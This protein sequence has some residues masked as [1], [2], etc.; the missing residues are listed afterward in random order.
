MNLFQ[1][2]YF[3]SSHCYRAVHRVKTE[4]GR[5]K[6][7]KTQIK[8]RKQ[9][10]TERTEQGSDRGGSEGGGGGERWRRRGGME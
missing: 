3:I 10:G 5:Y 1:P 4:K 6:F 7:N 2:D 9:G 8:I